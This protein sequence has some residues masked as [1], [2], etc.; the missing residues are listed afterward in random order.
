MDGR[1][2]VAEGVDEAERLWDLRKKAFFAAP[3]LRP[4]D[5]VG[6]LVTDVAVPL[7]RLV[8]SLG[9]AREML[10]RFGL[11]GPIVAHAG[12][13]NYHVLLVVRTGDVGEVERAELFR[14]VIGRRAIEMGGTCTGEHGVGEGKRE[15][16]ELEVGPEAIR[17]MRALKTTLD[18]NNILNPGKVL[19]PWRKEDGGAPKSKI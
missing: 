8:E 1:V 16:L 15:L 7:S 17:L 10:G 11:V 2:D 14:E 5:G 6:V 9:E 18:P 4:D 19:L 13:G 12:D 3:L